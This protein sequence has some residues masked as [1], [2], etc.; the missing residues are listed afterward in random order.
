MNSPRYLLERVRVDHDDSPESFARKV[1]L[2]AP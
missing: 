2:P 1:G